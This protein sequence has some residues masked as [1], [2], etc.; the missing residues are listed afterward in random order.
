MQD[1][2]REGVAQV[3]AQFRRAGVRTIMITGDQSAT[4]HAVGKQI[5]LSE[6]GHLEIVDSTRLDQIGPEVLTALAQRADVFSRVSPAHKLQIVQALQ[7]AG[8]VVAMTGDGVNDSPALRAADIGIAMGGGGT[9]A[10][11]EVA[12]V[13][14]EGD[15][16]Q[17][18][19]LAIE[20]GRTIYADLRKAVRFILSTNLGE[21]LYT[22]TCMAAGLGES[23]SPMQLLWINLLTDVLPELALA[24]QPPEADVL[25][26]PPRDPERPMF[27]QSDLVKI[28]GEGVVITA[29]ALAAYLWSRSRTG[30]GQRASTVG[31]TA[32]TLAQLAHAW[33]VRSE[34]HTVFE[35][36]D[37]PRNRWLPLAV[38]GTMFLQVLAN[39]TPP[40]RAL[41]GTARLSGSDW[42]L[43]GAAAVGPLIVNETIKVAQ[44]PAPEPLV[45]RLVKG[46]V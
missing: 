27:T 36:D 24:V 29:G 2:P 32:L 21:I 44:R 34:S 41:L 31:F 35:H 15:D 10:A 9:T 45:R 46:A 12:D 19:V 17:T 4:A 40:L 23:L 22:F 16:L 8:L 20:Q 25:A 1:P 6:N 38:G 28:G 43:A 42:L 3:I 7:R 33:S 14:L 37:R 13:V 18:L 11:R 26:R 39:L 30:P 5:G